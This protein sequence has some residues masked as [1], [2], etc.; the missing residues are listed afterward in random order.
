MRSSGRA[1]AQAV[2][3]LGEVGPRAQGEAAR[4]LGD[5]QPAL[6]AVALGELGQRPLHG[7]GGSSVRS[8]SAT[9]GSGSGLRKSSASIWRASPVTAGRR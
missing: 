9:S 1:L 8:Q 5:L 4:D 3:D 2:A 6:G 7:P